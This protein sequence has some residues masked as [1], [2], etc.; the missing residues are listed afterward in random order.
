MVAMLE[1]VA[2]TPCMPLQELERLSAQ[3]PAVLRRRADGS[4]S[5]ETLTL[6][7]SFASLFAPLAA[8]RDYQ[9]CIVHWE[10]FAAMPCLSTLD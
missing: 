3:E 9:G 2:A 6:P 8:A 7:G 5:A 4:L 10:K 1:A